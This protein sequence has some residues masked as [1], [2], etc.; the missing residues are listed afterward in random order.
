MKSYLIGA[1]ALLV[2]LS[3]VWWYGS[4]RYDT[5]YSQARTDML[6]ESQA[7]TAAAQQEKDRAESLY[8]GAVLARDA[9]AKTADTNLARFNRLL[10]TRASNAQGAE[11]TSGADGT[12]ATRD[13]V[14]AEC[15]REYRTMG[16]HAGRLADKVNGW[17]GYGAVMQRWGN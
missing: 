15:V 9:Y 16:E 6:A 2:L 13:L 8:R 10:A 14:L 17:Q 12:G 11:P 5:G 4:S 1:A 7:A 3:S